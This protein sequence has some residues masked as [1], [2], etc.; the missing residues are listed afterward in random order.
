MPH[1]R[2]VMRTLVML[3]SLCCFP[4]RGEEKQNDLGAVLL[5]FQVHILLFYLSTSP[6]QVPVRIAPPLQRA[7]I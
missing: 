5:C 2:V 1:V 3:L 4:I 7:T 6:L